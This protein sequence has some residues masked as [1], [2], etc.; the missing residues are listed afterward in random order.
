MEF[1]ERCDNLYY[2]HLDNDTGELNYKCKKCNLIEPYSNVG[3]LG[4]KYLIKTNIQKQSSSYNHII[5]QYT[6]LDCTLPRINHIKC[7]SCNS[8]KEGSEGEVIFIRYDDINLKYIYLCCNSDCK[9]I[10]KI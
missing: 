9:N 4:K 10:W 7:P 3:G 8:E 6:H 1:C 2:I 5:N